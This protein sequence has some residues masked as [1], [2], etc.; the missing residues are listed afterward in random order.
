VAGRRGVVT[1]VAI[2]AIVAIVSLEV[3]ALLMGV[4]G[5]ALAASTGT[6]GAVGG[7]L[8]RW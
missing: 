8:A 2:T 4:D 1:S 6:I 3:T 5:L 7:A